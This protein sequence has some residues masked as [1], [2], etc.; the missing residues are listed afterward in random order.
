M[1]LFNELRKK[2]NLSIILVTHDIS[3]VAYICQRVAV[4]YAGEIVEMGP[5]NSILEKPNHPYTMG[6]NNAFPDLLS[7]DDLLVPIEF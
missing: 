6:L 7:E 3:V 5:V 4:M 2:L 1:D